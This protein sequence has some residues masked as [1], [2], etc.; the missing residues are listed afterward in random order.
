MVTKALPVVFVFVDDKGNCKSLLAR[1]RALT[2][3]LRNC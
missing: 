2:V 3:I 1:K